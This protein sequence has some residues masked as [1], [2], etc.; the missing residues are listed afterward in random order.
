MR[1]M[2]GYGRGECTLH[3][4]KFV[5]EIKSVNSRYNDITIKAPRSL[6]EYEE[7]IL[8]IL[9]KEILRGKTDLYI[10]FESYAK[11]DV[12][13]V[14]NES[15]ADEYY[16]NLKLLKHK[17]NI[18][19]EVSLTLLTK[20]PDVL[21]TQE[22]AYNSDAQEEMQEALE[23]A[24]KSA[25][26]KFLK[27]RKKEGIF[28]AE[29]ILKRLST[30]DN[31]ITKVSEKLPY[32]EE[33]YKNKMMTRINELVSNQN[34]DEGRVLTEIAIF[35]EKTCI[36]EELTRLE[37]HII[38]MQ[39]I[40]LESF[41]IGKKMDFVVQEMNREVNTIASKVSDIEI[42]RYSLELKNEIEKIR[43]QVQNI[44]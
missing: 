28:L 10:S 17:Y 31:L 22:N 9:K 27:M 36:S 29:D 32:L 4:R 20:F 11:S 39:E 30:I 24:L 40:L 34:I 15:L 13:V 12:R 21:S 16:R 33:N 6:N 44:E 23:I 26:E 18:N 38:Q 25:L 14:L 5:V 42:K 19:E 35:C 1:S 3:N 2:T 37:S 8:S 7:K 43:E 41:S